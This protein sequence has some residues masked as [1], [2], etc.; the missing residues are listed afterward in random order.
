MS[1]TTRLAEP[2]LPG[3][4]L[5]LD[6]TVTDRVT[7]AAV[8]LTD[9]AVEVTAYVGT[10]SEAVP[11]TQ[12]SSNVWQALIGPGL[13]IAARGRQVKVWAWVTPEGSVEATGV[14]ILFNVKP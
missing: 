2:V 1:T 4:S 14:E 12:T 6:L 8:N 10:T 3:E 9:A 5:P 13:T 7:G 11:V